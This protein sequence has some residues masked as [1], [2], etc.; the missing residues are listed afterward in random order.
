MKH[1]VDVVVMLFE[2]VDSGNVVGADHLSD[3]HAVDLDAVSQGVEQVLSAG[4]VGLLSVSRELVQSLLVL[5]DDPTESFSNAAEKILS[6]SL[7]RLLLFSDLS[8]F[9]EV[10]GDRYISVLSSSSS[11]ISLLH[12]SVI[13]L[14]HSHLRFVPLGIRAGARRSIKRDA[15]ILQT[16]ALLWTSRCASICLG[17]ANLAIPIP[18]HAAL[19]AC[20]HASFSFS[21][22]AFAIA[23]FAIGPPALNILLNLSPFSIELFWTKFLRGFLNKFAEF[24]FYHICVAGLH[25]LSFVNRLSDNFHL[26]L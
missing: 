8:A 21:L 23:A 13:L 18:V 24:L 9:V 2:A 22:F 12:D 15:S 4:L 6:L 19:P 7:N 1:S 26:N 11:R 25:R 5:A 3:S 16:V 17:E 10:D 20:F 14:H